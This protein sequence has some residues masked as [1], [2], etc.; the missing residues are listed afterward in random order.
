MLLHGPPYA[1][2]EVGG[3]SNIIW[4]RVFRQIDTFETVSSSAALPRFSGIG[5]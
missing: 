4:I 3:R 5:R 1:L 2:E